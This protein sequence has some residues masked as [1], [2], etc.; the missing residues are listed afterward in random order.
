MRGGTHA[1]KRAVA[2]A[3]AAAVIVATVVGASSQTVSTTASTAVET[4]PAQVGYGA[5][6]VL[7]TL[8]YT[9][10]KATFCTLGS[11]VGVTALPFGTERAGKIVGAS[12][13]GSWVITPDVVKGK[14]PVNFVGDTSVP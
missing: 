6:S 13:R 12:C 2:A 14:E 11:I 9:P 5:A 4:T 10:F 1:V 3:S 7:G 8:I